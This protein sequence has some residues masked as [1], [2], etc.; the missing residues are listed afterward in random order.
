MRR[1]ISNK[2][3][4]ILAVAAGVLILLVAVLSLNPPPPTG[5]IYS[6]MYIHGLPVGGLTSEEADAALMQQ[7]QPSLDEIT[8]TFIHQGQIVAERSYK[9]LGIQL[10]FTEVIQV[11]RDYSNRRNLPSR[12]ARLLGRP[13][14]VTL[15]PALDYNQSKIEAQLQEI[16]SQVELAPQN[17]SFAYDSG[18]I[19][20]IEE[21]DG[22]TVDTES[23]QESLGEMI[24]SF[25]GGA[26]VFNTSTI[27]PRFTIDDLN[28][29]VF[30]IG[31]YSTSIMDHDA[32]P[33]VRNI[34]RA[35]DRIHN[36]M[37]FPGDVFS[38]SALIGVHLPDSDYEKAIVLVRGEPV[39]DV[40]GGICQVVTT[41]YNAVLLS[42]L[43]VVQRH[44][45]SARVSYADYGF[46]ATIAGD[47]YDFKFKNNTAHPILIVS[48]L[49][50]N[51]LSVSIY[52]NETRPPNRSLQFSSRRVDVIPPDPY[53]EV[54]DTTLA[55]G[56]RVVT[57]ESQ[58]GY[59]FE[60]FKHV[61]I[62]GEEVEEIKVNTS[63]YRPLQ[64]VISVGVRS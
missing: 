48:R 6:N 64:G 27:P 19:S 30:A 46:D 14:K 31:T 2:T 63:S 5:S 60:V 8:I 40:G 24:N 21:A 61:F 22:L 56:Q 45:H 20:I 7:F 38:A 10:D 18:Q 58:M 42:E 43:T 17:A 28:F 34:R 36:H 39:E 11:A 25:G 13:H 51:A 12:I 32:D 37:L 4:S 50:P 35:S 3:L 47:Y 15:E 9:D 16:V 52:G 53:K 59:R 41:L 49:E 44:N 57:L 33:R 1:N 55:P 62:N 54:V 29:E 23:A 26:V